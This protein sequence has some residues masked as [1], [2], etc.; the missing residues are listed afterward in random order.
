MN[1]TATENLCSPRVMFENFLKLQFARAFRQVQFE[2][3]E[4][5]NFSQM[6]N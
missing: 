5:S 2:S 3:L 1:A 6:I 4:F